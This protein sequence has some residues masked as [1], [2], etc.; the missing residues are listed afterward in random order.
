MFFHFW[1]NGFKT[2]WFDNVLIQQKNRK[3]KKNNH[4][5]GFSTKCLLAKSLHFNYFC[6]KYKFSSW[7][8]FNTRVMIFWLSKNLISRSFSFPKN[9]S[10]FVLTFLNFPNRQSAHLFKLQKVKS[11]FLDFSS[12]PEIM[13][14]G[15]TKVKIRQIKIIHIIEIL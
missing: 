10:N 5:F 8:K 7:Q 14:E 2:F 3:E 6:Q 15:L 4:P 13:L 11:I 1:S 9:Y 12:N